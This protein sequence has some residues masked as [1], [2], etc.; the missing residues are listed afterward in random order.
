MNICLFISDYI[1]DDIITSKQIRQA[2]HLSNADIVI[3]IM[4]KYIS[5]EGIIIAEDIELRKEYA[6]ANGVD[7][8]INHPSIFS[9]S[10][11]EIYIK[12]ILLTM[13]NLGI[14]NNFYLMGLISNEDLDDINMA[15]DMLTSQY[16]DSFLSNNVMRIHQPQ[17]NNNQIDI[18]N[19]LTNPKNS[20]ILSIYEECKRTHINCEIIPVNESKTI[21]F[22][23]NKIN[24]NVLNKLQKQLFSKIQN[25]DIK[26]ML[27]ITSE[28]SNLSVDILNKI[29]LLHLSQIKITKKEIVEMLVKY[30]YLSFIFVKPKCKKLVQEKI[31]TKDQKNNLLD[32]LD[33]KL[34]AIISYIK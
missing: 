23:E 19:M 2:K 25:D 26:L 5:N 32:E 10:N 9:L 24:T 28:N 29:T 15:K 33:K 30:N 7:V 12:S 27:D 31:I 8:I 18:S 17:K 22:I 6:I 4:N 21:E 14:N 34:F 3:C 20:L 16:K 1:C 13:K 11:K